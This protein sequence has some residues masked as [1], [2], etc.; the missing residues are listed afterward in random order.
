MSSKQ[1]CEKQLS[2]N[3]PASLRLLTAEDYKRVFNNNPLKIVCPPYTLLA[4]PNHNDCSRIGLIVAKKNVRNAVD[5]NRIKR[6]ARESFRLNQH[7]I[8]AYD[9][10]LLARR[11][12][13]QLPNK[14]L[15]RHL[16]QLWIRLQKRVSK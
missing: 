11:G 8:P 15:F 13:S 14:V 1:T 3:F 10:V 2:A 6:L 4:A 16:E 5:R 9:I 12:S 7:Q